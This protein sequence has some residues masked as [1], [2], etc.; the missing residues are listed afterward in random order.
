MAGLLR[1]SAGSLLV[2]LTLSARVMPG[3]GVSYLG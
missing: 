3:A 1:S 2:P